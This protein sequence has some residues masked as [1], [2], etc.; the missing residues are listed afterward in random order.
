VS[1]G[2]LFHFSVGNATRGALGLALHENGHVI[3]GRVLGKEFGG[4]T[5]VPTPMLGGL[6]WDL[7]TSARR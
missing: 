5:I 6:A 7:P 3:V 2:G 1:I 4:V